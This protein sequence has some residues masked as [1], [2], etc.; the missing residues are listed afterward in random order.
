MPKT[1]EGKRLKKYSDDDIHKAIEAV[2]SGMP[3]RETSKLYNAIRATLQFKLSEKFVKVEH[4]PKK[5]ETTSC[6]SGDAEIMPKVLN[7][8]KSVNIISGIAI[9]A[10]PNENSKRV[11]E[12][13]DST[14]PL[15]DDK[16]HERSLT[17]DIVFANNKQQ[18]MWIGVT[19]DCMARRR[20][21]WRLGDRRFE[22]AGSGARSQ[23]SSLQINIPPL[24]THYQLLTITSV[25]VVSSERQLALSF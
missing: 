20:R 5:M 19:T 6:E 14:L 24:T 22:R 11:S 3:K 16:P 25:S 23:L 7:S 18:Q 4:D 15:S 2:K 10:P 17:D 8:F 21:A 9:S 13:E 12:E 1:E